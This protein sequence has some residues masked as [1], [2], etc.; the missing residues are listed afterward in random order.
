MRTTETGH[1][2]I[3]TEDRDGKI[4]T[5]NRDGKNIPI[6][7]TGR[8]RGQRNFKSDSEEDL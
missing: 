8:F 3:M 5:E 1:M 4:M 6:S 7:K 2:K